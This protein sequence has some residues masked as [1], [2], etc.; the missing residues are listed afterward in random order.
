MSCQSWSRRT[1]VELLYAGYWWMVA[2]L[3]GTVAGGAALLPLEHTRRWAFLRS[4][5]R[6]RKR[7]GECLTVGGSG[8]K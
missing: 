2:G 5:S 8:Q 1:A 7:F 4:L 3:L 6:L